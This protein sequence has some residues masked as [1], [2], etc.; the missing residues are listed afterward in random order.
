M[1]AA[2]IDEAEEGQPDEER[3]EVGLVGE[4]QLSLAEALQDACPDRLD[5]IDGIELRPEA[6]RDLAANHHAEMGFVG[7]EGLLDRIDIAIVQPLEELEREFIALRFR[8][9]VG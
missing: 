2:E 7:L 3:S 4:P 6:L 9:G 5:D 8:R 1:L